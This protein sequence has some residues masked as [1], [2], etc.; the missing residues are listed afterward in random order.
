MSLFDAVAE[1]PHG[2]MR[3]IADEPIDPRAQEG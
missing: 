2:T 1:Q 3:R